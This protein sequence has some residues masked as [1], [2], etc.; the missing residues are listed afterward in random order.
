VLSDQALFLLADKLEISI[1][2]TQ[3]LITTLNNMRGTHYNAETSLKKFKTYYFQVYPK[4]S[5]EQFLK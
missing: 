4:I 2:I 3:K 5:K 1:L